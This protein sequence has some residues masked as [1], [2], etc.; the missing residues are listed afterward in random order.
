MSTED[1]SD[2]DEPRHP[3]ETEDSFHP[4]GEQWENRMREELEETDY[5]ADL[6]MQMAR[7]AQRLVAGEIS[8]EEFYAEYHDDVKEEFETDERPIFDDLEG[9][10]IDEFEDESLL[11]SLADVDLSADDVSRREMMNKMGA[12]GLFLGYSAFATYDDTDDEV[13]Q[14]VDGVRPA[15]EDER[16]HRWGMTIDLERCDGCLACVSGCISENGTSTGANW[17]YVFT[18]EDEQSESE[19]PNQ[20]VRPCQH[21][22]NAPCAKVCPVRARHTRSKDGIVLTNYEVCIGCRYCQVACPY[23]VN[24]FQWGDPDVEMS[25]LEHVDMTPDEVRALDPGEDAET[26]GGHTYAAEG[27]ERLNALQDANDHV[28]DGRG[29]WV[30]SRPPIGTMGKC[31]F[32]PSRQDN[33]TGDNGNEKGS[34]ACMDACDQQGMS[35]IHFGDLDAE[36]G[37]DYDRAVRYLEERQAKADNR[38]RT[39]K[40]DANIYFYD[41]EVSSDTAA[42]AGAP[43]LSSVDNGYY[44]LHLVQRD[45]GSS[46]SEWGVYDTE[47]VLVAG[48]A[49]PEGDFSGSIGSFGGVPSSELQVLNTQGTT[50]IPASVVY[51]GDLGD[52]EVLE[53]TVSLRLGSDGETLASQ[54]LTVNEAGASQDL[55]FTV[56]GGSI[57]SPEGSYVLYL[58]VEP[59]NGEVSAAAHEGVYLTAGEPNVDLPSAPY[60][61]VT[62]QEG[63]LSNVP[64]ILHKGGSSEIDATISYPSSEPLDAQIGLV[65]YNGE[66]EEVV[67]QTEYSFEQQY[68]SN[69]AWD[70][71]LSTFKL[72]EDLGTSPNITYI[73]NEPGPNA[74]Q[75]SAEEMPV[76]YADI[77]NKWDVQVLDKRLERLKYGANVPEGATVGGGGGGGDH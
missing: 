39:N 44:S 63:S 20:L 40:F 30:D 64:N 55:T 23:G 34:V 74:E 65:L 62:G 4:M 75:V 49:L 3:Y 21:C 10:D 73:G 51:D 13:P 9:V 46:D 11:E 17:M 68:T 2:T 26:Y 77:S 50:E 28:Y 69:T 7:D 27:S 29:W 38:D 52:G 53:T 76:A 59:A 1:P 42:S 61:S 43:D 6:G 18:Y 33:T 47:E 14:L 72:L 24:Y 19:N 22:S 31:T 16:K 36:V 8:E 48:S 45:A 66:T 57:E 12:A 5:D 37:D 67:A 15:D 32:C 58:A 54:S 25:R 41:T 60:G 35:A 71:G 56:N 70:S